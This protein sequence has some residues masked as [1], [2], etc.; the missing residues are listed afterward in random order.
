QI[1]AVG[2]KL[3]RLSQFISHSVVI[4]YIMG[5]TIAVVTNQ[6]FTLLGIARMPG[7]HSLYERG[8][9]LLYHLN[10]FH[11]PTA[12][13]GIFSLGLILILKRI[14]KRIPAAFITLVVTGIFIHVA[15][16][17][18]DFFGESFF[19]FANSAKLALNGIERVSDNGILSDIIPRVDFPHFDMRDMNAL[20][21]T[22][23]AIAVLSVMETSS[24]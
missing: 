19:D 24:A 16:L 15:H 21:P 6:I 8:V 1:L 4:G 23:F 22:A 17:T 9:Y 11:V 18:L 5:T 20:L 3:G 7:V 13:I 10:E 2:L 12:I 14:N